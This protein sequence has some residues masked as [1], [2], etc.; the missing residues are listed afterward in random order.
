MDGR[1]VNSAGQRRAR[2]CDG[3]GP[4]QAGLIPVQRSRGNTDKEPVVRPKPIPADEPDRWTPLDYVAGCSRVLSAVI[5]WYLCPKWCR[6]KLRRSVPRAF[7]GGL[8]PR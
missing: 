8:G 2:P 4:D 7:R 1:G 5:D 6:P 3:G